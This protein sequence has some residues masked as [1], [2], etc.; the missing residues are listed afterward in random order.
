M[1]DPTFFERKGI[2]QPTHRLNQPSGAINAL[3]VVVD[4]SDNVHTVTA[5]YFDSLIFDP[6]VSGRG[7]VRDYY[8][9]VSYSQVDI[10]TVDLPSS[11]G[12]IM[13]PQTYA[14]YVN[15]NYCW[16]SYPQ[17]CQRLAEDIVDAVNG[18]VNFSNYDADNDGIMEPI[19]LVHA[20]PGAEFTGSTWDVW[21]HSW[22]LANPRFYDG[23]TIDRY[24][25]M[26]EFWQ[27]VSPSTS[28]MTI[29]VFA[30]EMGHG[31]W[32]LPDF[33]DYG[34]DSWGIG[35]WSLMSFG[36][37]NGP[38]SGGWGSDGSSPAWPDA[39]CRIVMGFDSAVDILGPMSVVFP[40]VEQNQ[41]AISRFNSSGLVPPEYF[42]VENRQ[43]LSGTYDEYLAGSGVLIWH[44]DDSMSNNDNQCTTIPHCSG[45]CQA[46][47]YWVA[48][49]QADGL[50]DL[51]N[52][53]PNNQGDGGD[54]FPGST[55]RTF[56]QPYFMNPGTNPESG[57]W[58][59]NGCAIDSCIDITN[60]ACQALGNCTASVNRALCPP[61]ELLADLGDAP[62]SSNSFGLP[63]TAYPAMGPLPTVQ[64]NFPTVFLPVPNVPGPRHR[65]SQVDSWL[66]SAVSIE[67]QG[68]LGPDQDINRNISPTLDLAD[69]DSSSIFPGMD[70]GLVMPV[71]LA[72]CVPNGLPFTITVAG[73]TMPRYVNAWFDWNRDGDW[74][75][76]PA[77]PGGMPAPEWAVQDEM[78]TLGAGTHPWLSMPFVP[79]IVTTQD[80][81]F[82]SWMRLSIADT[83]APVPQDGRGPVGQYLYGE[84]EDYYLFLDPWLTQTSDLA[85]DPFPGELVTLRIEFTG[86][87]NVIAAGGR[88]SDVLPAGVEYID[89]RPPGIYDPGTRTVVWPANL[90]P[91]ILDLIELD[92]QVTGA[93][94]DTI[95]NPAYL[96]W[97][98][99][100]W[101]QADYIFHIGQPCDPNDPTAAYTFTQPACVDETVD[102]TNLTIGTQPI[103][104]AWD[105]DGDGL[106]DSTDEHPSWTYG[107]AGDHLVTLVANNVCGQSV[108][109]DVVTVLQTLE[110]LDIAGPAGLL[111]GEEGLYTAL[112]T[113]PDAE[114]PLYQWDNGTAGITAT[115]SWDTPGSYTIVLTGSNDCALL[116]ATLD[117]LV[118]AECVSLTG[119][120][121]DGPS[122]LAAGEEGTYLATPEPLTATNPSY[123]WDNGGTGASA[124][125]SWTLPGIYEIVVTATNCDD[126]VVTDTFTVEVLACVTLT[127]VTIDGPISL[128]V[129]EEG[130]YTASPEPPDADEPSY[131][132][133]DGT[134]GATAVYSWT[135]P[136][137][138]DVLVTATNCEDTA[139][140]DTLSVLVS[141]ECIS[142]T[143]VAITGPVSL[144]AGEEGTYLAAPEP[145]T[146]TNPGYLWSNGAAASSAVYSWT[147]PG[148]YT[149]AITATNCQTVVVNDS[150]EIVVTEEVVFRI[151]LPLVL[152]DY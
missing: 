18:V 101:K 5:S 118:T 89:S 65:L 50:D 55:G 36:S 140:T 125:Y 105:L 100:I 16:G 38:N 136:G 92:L 70:D 22:N 17:N 66:G 137:T 35:D 53:V 8:D 94:S 108:Y 110:G 14:W 122:T 90:Q 124:S 143:G 76:T 135:T 107:T 99:D 82:E 58:Y 102:F 21:S 68:D 61:D 23:V 111:I 47:H 46:Q 59:D 25:I 34:Y 88:I 44:V 15:G 64:A 83:T 27:T 95:V 79:W 80:L 73:G 104:Y 31:F 52:N 71:P 87:G 51:E 116:T 144:E 91:G 7:S 49:E 62:A 113:P 1:T 129:G 142:L 98:N 32:G 109:S 120:T 4:F 97:T 40:P 119:V 152:R 41:Y 138:Y 126:V 13:A 112:P 2:N 24:V 96:L 3:A 86:W 56:W 39:W 67:R 6:P 45:A 150:L 148:T 103:S 33:Y 133:N 117:V 10:V 93:P 121:V 130:T 78:T 20:G 74:A 106:V 48:L 77:C 128:L 114:D 29:G 127:D 26:P 60:I 57:T 123:Q 139:V 84:T 149:V 147:V 28:D 146:A 85:H 115:Y 134:T 42:L 9:E 75:D 19:M 72:P 54:P 43:Q 11:L 69:M 12:W 141:A 151:Y 37:W 145:L 30:H 131:L 132:W 63:M 81:P